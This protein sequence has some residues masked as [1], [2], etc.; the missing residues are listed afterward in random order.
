MKA[1]AS[2]LLR[3]VRERL[4]RAATCERNNSTEVRVTWLQ[5]DKRRARWEYSTYI[6]AFL[7]VSSDS[8]LV[9]RHVR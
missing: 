8:R 3:V 2:L 9:R 5:V 1:S 7:Q 6:S 4:Y